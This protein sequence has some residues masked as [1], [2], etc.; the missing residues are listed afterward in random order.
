M[1]LPQ[2][3]QIWERKEVLRSVFL[4]LSGFLKWSKASAT[5]RLKTS[6]RASHNPITEAWPAQQ[7]ASGP[8]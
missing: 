3:P 4:S 7:D 8:G 2:G 1:I 5:T 6:F